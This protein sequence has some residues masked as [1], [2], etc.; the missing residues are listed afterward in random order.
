M[1]ETANDGT[2][3]P[4]RRKHH[5]AAR[6][7]DSWHRRRQRSARRRGFVSTIIPTSGYGAPDWIRVLGRVVLTRPGAPAPE[8][9]AK[10]RGWRSFLRIPSDESTLTLR[11]AG[12]RFTVPIG[13]G[14]VVDA[15]VD[16]QLPTGWNE[17]EL[18]ASD[19]EAVRADVFVVDPGERFGVISDVDDTVMVTMLPRPFVAAWNTFVV[20]EHARIPVAGMAVLYSLLRLEHPGS[21]LVYL[22]TGAWNVAPTLRRFLRRNLYPPGPFLLTDWG[23]TVDRFF[24]SGLEHKRRQLRRLAD[25]FPEIRWLL[26]GD[27]GQHDEAIYAEFAA[28]FP[29]RVAGVCIRQLT[30]GEVVLAGGRKRQSEPG[31]DSPVPWFFAPDGAGLLDQLRR[32]GLVSGR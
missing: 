25:E 20:D 6:I 32:A 1:S 26:I 31:Q 14:G 27:D 21:P 29:E 3:S 30:P 7:E 28:E 19:G 8:R 11:V 15:R 2:P 10:V 12:R 18:Q 24:R 13:R 16:V 9:A 17:L 4:R 23:P 5:L 22:S